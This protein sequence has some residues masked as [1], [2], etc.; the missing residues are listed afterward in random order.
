MT[1]WL[2][3]ESAADE[4]HR[5]NCSGADIADVSMI[6]DVGPVLAEDGAGVGV[7]FGLPDDAHSG[8]FKSEIESADACEK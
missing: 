1:E 2:A 8:S 6:G 3:G 5:F 4:V 7:D